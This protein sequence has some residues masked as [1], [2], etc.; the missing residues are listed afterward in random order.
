M[1]A[2][3]RVDFTPQLRRHVE[4]PAEEAGGAT[5]R[6]AL[7]AYFTR[8]PATRS[9]VLDE[10][11]ELRRHV[12]V[13]VDGVMLRDRRRQADPVRADSEILVMQALSGG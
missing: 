3:P 1:A 7:E 12:T 8:H 11:G 2:V 5:V 4:C 10:Q 6:E 13:F 9:Y